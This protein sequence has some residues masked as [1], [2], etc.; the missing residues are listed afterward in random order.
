VN[1]WQIIADHLS[2]TGW[3][4]G[5]TSAIHE[6]AGQVFIVD[7]HRADSP[8]RFIVR[9]DQLLTAFLELEQQ[10]RQSTATG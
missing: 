6:Q 4:W 10:L 1:Y 3:S 5:V 8:A 7:A 9:S 2:A